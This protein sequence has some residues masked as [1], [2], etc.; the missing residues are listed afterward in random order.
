LQKP[1]GLTVLSQADHTHLADYRRGPALRP[2]ASATP[3]LSKH[4]IEVSLGLYYPA[5]Q[6]PLGQLN[7]RHL[8]L[9]QRTG[10]GVI[11]AMLPWRAEIFNE[12]RKD[13]RQG[14]P[15]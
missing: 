12:L 15:W 13:R 3:H 1:D 8:P 4:S 14:M 10:Y 7:E 11:L 9:H 5:I 2:V 6:N